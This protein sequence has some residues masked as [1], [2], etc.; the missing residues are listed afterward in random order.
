MPVNFVSFYDSLRFAN[1]LHNGQPTGAQGN[2]TT[3]D[4]AY[5]FSGPTTVGARNAG[6]Q[7]FLP[8]ENE[9]YKAAYY[10]APTASYFDYPTGSNTI[11]TCALPGATP[12]TANC[13]FV[14]TDLTPVGSYTGSAS[15]MGTFDQGGNVWE[16]NEGIPGPS[17]RSLRAGGFADPANRLA[18]LES[19]GALEASA[20]SDVGFRVASI[21]L[22][23]ATV[24][25]LSP[26]GMTVLWSLLGLAGLRS[27]RN[28]R[29]IA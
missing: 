26:I 21:S 12:N 11:P 23:P 18:P 25:S 9:W 1:W 6:A 8:S 5:T 17:A 4:G 29:S 3:E 14:V 16:W 10:R 22:I 27:V 20:I 28:R 24:P 2:S 7:I 15:P 13:N 19:T